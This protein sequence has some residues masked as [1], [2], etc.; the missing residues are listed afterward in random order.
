MSFSATD[1]QLDDTCMDIQMSEKTPTSLGHQLRGM[2]REANAK[3][4]SLAVV[5]MVEVVVIEM[6]KVVVVVV[7]VVVVEMANIVVVVVEIVKVVV[8]ERR[9]LLVP[10]VVT[11]AVVEVVADIVVVAD[12]DVAVIV[13]CFLRLL[14]HSS[15]VAVIVCCF[16][17]LRASR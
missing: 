15:A 11:V 10:L 12:I 2:E 3:V 9:E 16:L 4:V 17:R 8:W 7:V 1:C 6:A 13:C 5:V 14:Q